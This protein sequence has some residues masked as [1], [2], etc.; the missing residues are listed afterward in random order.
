MNRQVPINSTSCYFRKALELVI[1][2]YISFLKLTHTDYT[3][4]IWYVE[5][6]LT[7]LSQQVHVYCVYLSYNLYIV[8]VCIVVLTAIKMFIVKEQTK[9]WSST[10]TVYIRTKRTIDTRLK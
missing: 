4:I 5:Y 10:F 9:K 3:G 8:R 7:Q 2:F 1:Y 6:I